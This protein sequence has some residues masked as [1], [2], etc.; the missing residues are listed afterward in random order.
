MKFGFDQN[1]KNASRLNSMHGS[2][3]EKFPIVADQ[4]FPITDRCSVEA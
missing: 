4:Q 3:A 2:M 1:S